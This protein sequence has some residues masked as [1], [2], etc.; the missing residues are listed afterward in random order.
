[1]LLVIQCEPDSYALE[2]AKEHGYSY[3]IKKN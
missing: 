1:V 2:Y 3:K